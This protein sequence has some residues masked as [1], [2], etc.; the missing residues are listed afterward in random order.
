M[1]NRRRSKKLS[2][3]AL[4]LQTFDLV[5]VWMRGEANILADPPSRAPWEMGVA[6]HLPVPDMPIRDLVRK[7]HQDPDG[8]EVLVRRRAEEMKVG[9]WEPIGFRD[10]SGFVVGDPDED[11]EVEIR[12][13]AAQPGYETPKFGYEE[14][15]RMFAEIGQG[16]VLW[17][18]GGSCPYFPV[19]LSS[20][21]QVEKCLAWADGPRPVP[22]NP[23]DLPV[24]VC[25]V[26]N[27]PKGIFIGVRWKQAVEF[28]DGESRASMWLSVSELG[29][30]EAARQAWQFFKQR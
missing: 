1:N 3:W 2:N 6:A 8:V 18:G 19:F 5:R 27:G 13:P 10:D 7:M 4:D 24:D 12:R 28:T 21:V 17:A 11:T 30:A 16:Q 22:K 20:E 15:A 29:E 23:Y 9:E 25:R 26:N 14:P